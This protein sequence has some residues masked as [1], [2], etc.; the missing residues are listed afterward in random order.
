MPPTCII[1]LC[2]WGVGVTYS[3]LAWSL[4]VSCGLSM[5]FY[6]KVFVLVHVKNS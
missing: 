5:A 4:M 3:G 2:F 6:G 1:A